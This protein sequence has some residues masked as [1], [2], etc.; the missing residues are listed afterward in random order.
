MENNNEP[1]L[2]PFGELL[3]RLLASLGIDSIAELRELLRGVG[4]DISEEEIRQYVFG[5][6]I[7]RN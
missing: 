3:R 1:R 2:T 4:Y 6:S 7:E 5:S